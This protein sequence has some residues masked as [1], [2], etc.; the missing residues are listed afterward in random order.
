MNP[1]IPML[2]ARA[3]FFQG[4]SASGRQTLAAIAIPRSVKKRDVLFM[5]GDHGHSMYL[6]LRG[7]I[8]LHKTSRHGHEVV[9][10]VL[11]PGDTFAEVIL[12]ESETYPVTAL[13]LGESDVL[14]FPRRDIQR[15]LADENFRRDFIGMTMKKLRYLTERILQI[16]TMDV[17]DRLLKF[18]REESAG[19]PTFQIGMSKKDIAAAIGTTPETVSRLISKLTDD[20][21]LTWKG[22]TVKLA[23]APTTPTTRSPNPPRPD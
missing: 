16:T 5:E 22:R 10:R 18:L 8:Q 21:R 7:R 11:R 12:F 23:P 17:E 2:L 3:G 4:L 20:R 14:L 13:A 1:N 19:Q 15:L 9:V 6:L